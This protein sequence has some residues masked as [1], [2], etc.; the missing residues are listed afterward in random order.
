M[1][2]RQLHSSLNEYVD[3]AAAHLRGEIAGGAEVP[4]E[5]GSQSSRG[6]GRGTPLYCYRALTGGFIAEREAALQ[7]LPSHA[8]AAKALEEFD[9]LDRYLASVA[10]DVRPGRSRG[11]ARL[12]LKALLE[13][14][15]AEQSDF[16]LRPERV[17]GA[18]ERL[19]SSAIAGP[20]ELTLVAAL[21]GV[22]ISSPQVA[23]ATGLSIAQAGALEDVP[24]QVLA[25]GENDADDA[26][27]V[28]VLHSAEK[29]DLD[30]ALAAGR[31]RLVALLRALRLFGD[32]RVAFAPLAWARVGAGSWVPVALG[33]GAV[34][35]G[36]LVV[37]V[38]QEDELRAF[39]NLV[40][41]RAPRGDRVAWALRRFELG[42]DRVNARDAL[43]DHL[44]ALRAVLE[45]EGAQ[46]AMLAGRVAT[47]CAKPQERAALAQRVAQAVELE[48]ALIEGTAVKQPAIAAASDELAQHLRALLSDVICGHLEPDLPALADEL[49]LAGIDAQDAEVSEPE[50]AADGPDAAEADL[51]EQPSAVE[52]ADKPQAA[53]QVPAAETAAATPETAAATPATAAAAPETAAAAPETDATAPETAAA[54]P[55]TDATA[56]G[57]APGAGE[58]DDAEESERLAT[59]SR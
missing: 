11:R 13:D 51:A 25:A 5:I 12:A 15:F 46:V 4:F 19:E 38:E 41:R 32:G 35:R 49:L 23:M 24:A 7:R 40:S 44:L 30:G 9:G 3:A 50:P 57:D 34:A 1:R 6:A 27:R 55:E 28:L 2:S 59:Q 43:T 8:A 54:A 20:K 37:T 53:E 10:P 42:C 18:L 39:F 26:Q 16:D 29:G 56:P 33:S 36:M 47:L 48:Q 17:R 31:E 58:H 21:Q 45:P 22:V 52:A 14:V